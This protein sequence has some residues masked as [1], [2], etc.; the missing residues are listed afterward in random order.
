VAD[1][2]AARPTALNGARSGVLMGRGG[3]R[4]AAPFHFGTKR[5]GDRVARCQGEWW[6]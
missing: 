4:V 2:V 1:Q 6:S 3:D 5:G